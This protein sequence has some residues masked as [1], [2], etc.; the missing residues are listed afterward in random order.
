MSVESRVSRAQGRT[1][2][3]RPS[4]RRSLAIALGFV[5]AWQLLPTPAFAVDPEPRA[6]SAWARLDLARLSPAERKRL[7]DALPAWDEPLNAGADSLVLP[8]VRAEEALQ[9]T[10]LR[11][12][13]RPAP[14]QS[15]SWPACVPRLD[16]LYAWAERI[17][18]ERP[19]LVAR[20]S[21]GPS[22]CRQAGGCRSP[23]GDRIS[24]DELVV[25]RVGRGGARGRLF[26]D[27][28]LHARELSPTALVQDTVDRLLAGYGADAQLTFL[29]DHRELH[30]GLASNPDGRRVVELG[31]GPPY[32]QGP[33]LQRKSAR[34]ARGS[35]CAWPPT[36]ED[37]DGVDLNRNHDFSWT[38]PG[39]SNDP[40]AETFRGPGPASEPETRAYEDYAR[41][42]FPD[43][44]GPGEGDAAPPDTSGILLN[45]HNFTPS[46][47]LLV[48][49]GYTAKD[50]PNRAGLE[51]IAR[52]YAA[53]S[54]YSQQ[55]SLYAVSGNTRDWAYGELGIPAYVLELR[56]AR[57]LSTCGEVERA[58]ADNA[59]AIDELLAL[60]DRP[61]E[62]IRGPRV[63]AI[64]PPD[65]VRQGEPIALRA[66]LGSPEPDAP[67]ISGAEIALGRVGGA[68]AAPG[69]PAPT[70]PSGGWLPLRPVD[71]AFDEVEEAAEGQI[72]GDSL[73]PGRHYL[74]LQ[75]RA[76]D[77]AWG[78]PRAVWL[79]VLPAPSATATPMP[80][81]I[82]TAT[83]TSTATRTATP[84]ATM[85]ST[86]TATPAP[87][88]TPSATAAPSPS[89][90]PSA[91][92]T[93]TPFVPA[94]S[95]W[96][97]LA[98]R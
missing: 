94:A 30:A 28:G 56:G 4:R 47:T 52:R 62:R 44:R 12:G 53:L 78:P 58:L 34:P 91:A 22:A 26:M 49:W 40:C 18:A 60:A 76:A 20:T 79:D 7:A 38:A 31:L 45:V 54:G 48:P 90:A 43:R 27:A 98:L 83:P 1:P 81:P 93:A 41:A 73:A 5:L 19:A 82:P 71:G 32:G 33:F 23:R 63:A 9:S 88:G 55:R 70:D 25:L 57:Y 84:T 77:G 69:L 95:I 51:A 92:R 3:P 67:I 65:P 2:A 21:A 66:V 97:P 42:I 74:V 85:R 80:T 39:H 37:Q 17:V 6:R 14:D 59:P 96:L 15:R 68:A 61:Y 46:G 13:L 86:L 64:E 50:P 11:A 10:G 75:A 29:L 89:S 8:R 72:D 87:S 24:G 36:A 16:A 35:A